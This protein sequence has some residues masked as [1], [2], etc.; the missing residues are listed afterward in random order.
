MKKILITFI[1]FTL[2]LGIVG[3][4]TQTPTDVV[5]SYFKELE[6]GDSQKATAYF[7]NVFPS[8]EEET[9]ED[10]VSKEIITKYISRID[11]K[12]VSEE[13]NED[14]ATVEVEIEAPNLS[15]LVMEVFQESLVYA[16]GG[17]DMSEE[18]MN[19]ILLEKVDSGECEIRT[20]KIN[21]VKEDNEWK[22]KSDD[23]IIA[24]M[25]GEAKVENEVNK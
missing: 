7:E 13:V 20:G 19:E 1:I 5:Q 2:T 11:A 4:S 18:D 23:N 15:N 12:V 6:N 9:E 22:I 16:F 21:L 14:T 8:N 25:L 3:C 10:E 24:L 17:T